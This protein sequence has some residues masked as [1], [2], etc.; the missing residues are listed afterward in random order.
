MK[1]TTQ[2]KILSKKH[3]PNFLFLFIRKLYDLTLLKIIPWIFTF[4]IKNFKEEMVI[5]LSYFGHNFSI[6]INPKNGYLDAQVYLY[7]EYERHIVKEIMRNLKDGDVVLD[8]GANIGIH[9]LF[10]SKCVNK[11]G[12]VVSFE[13]ISYIRN[14]FER[15]VLLNK[16][17]NITVLPFALGEKEA[18]EIIHVR[19]GNVGGSSLLGEST[20][21]KDEEIKVVSL[22][23][24]NLSPN[25][26][27]M[28]V[29]G[30]EYLALL[31]SESTI[32]KYK[33]KILME[34]SPIYYRM[35]GSSLFKNHDEK[36]IKFFRDN[37][38]DIYDLEDGRRRVVDDSSFVKSFG[39]NLRSQTNIICIPR[40]SQL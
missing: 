35:K 16:I 10:M 32:K 17:E 12:K 26:I 3:L 7:K 40:I 2:I 22:D 6:I 19:E 29:E 36:I 20:S 27:K 31:G 14:Q 1:S 18:I 8:V 9:S 25:F 30:Y 4:R 28:D 24:L 37:N 33:P 13:P 15:S 11:S 21:T 23:S 38:Y 39:D 34:Y 5:P